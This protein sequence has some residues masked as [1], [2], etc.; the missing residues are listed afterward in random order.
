MQKKRGMIP[1]WG[2][3]KGVARVRPIAVETGR[4]IKN[5]AV[6]CSQ[7]TDEIFTENMQL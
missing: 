6:M 2:S 4:C 7:Y 3:S 1:V 5:E